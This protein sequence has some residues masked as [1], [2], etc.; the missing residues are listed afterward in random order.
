MLKRILFIEDE[1][2]LADLYAM[3]LKKAGYEVSV[4]KD[5]VSGLRTAQNGNFD[6]ILLDLML[7]NMS[8]TDIL[9]ALRNPQKSPNFHGRIIILTNFGEDDETRR[10][11]E[12]LTDGYLLKV[13]YTP[14]ALVEYIKKLPP[15]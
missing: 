7:P 4:E 12:T 3:V 8:G 11:M 2:Q 10:K 14:R 1:T 5:G 15:A 9:T 6:L 13:N